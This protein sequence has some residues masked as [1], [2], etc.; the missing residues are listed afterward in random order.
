[1]QNIG[2]IGPHGNVK[3]PIEITGAKLGIYNIVAG[4]SSDKVELV[5]GEHKVFMVQ[6]VDVS[7]MLMSLEYFAVIIMD[8]SNKYY[9]NSVLHLCIYR[10]LQL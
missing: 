10:T 7:Y 8:K 5:S 6:V 2:P 3:Y 4:L 9:L 1:M